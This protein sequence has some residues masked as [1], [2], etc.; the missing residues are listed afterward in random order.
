MYNS[1]HPTDPEELCETENPELGLVWTDNHEDSDHGVPGAQ[2]YLEDG[3]WVESR[4]V[5]FPQRALGMGPPVT[6]VKRG[7]AQS[8]EAEKRG[9]GKAGGLRAPEDRTMG[10]LPPGRCRC[11]KK[12]EGALGTTGQGPFSLGLFQAPLGFVPPGAESDPAVLLP[13]MSPRWR[14]NKGGRRAEERANPPR[15]W[16]FFP[17]WEC[18]CDFRVTLV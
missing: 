9:Q 15:W 17:K 4:E 13:E 3:G 5:F 8:A 6:S 1:S 10:V 18:Q 14:K 11:C 12:Q 7:G 16:L 2:F